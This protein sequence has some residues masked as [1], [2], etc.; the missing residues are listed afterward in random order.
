MVIIRFALIDA[1]Y[2]G[3]SHQ[4]MT[5]SHLDQPFRAIAAQMRAIA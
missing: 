5:T 1:V 3:A 4:F 2:V